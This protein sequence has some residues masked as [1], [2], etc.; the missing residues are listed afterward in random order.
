MS[1]ADISTNHFLANSLQPFFVIEVRLDDLLIEQ[2]VVALELRL[3]Y[4]L[5][6]RL[7]GIDHRAE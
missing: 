7:D 4:L 3:R 1:R 6:Y 2:Y 5:L